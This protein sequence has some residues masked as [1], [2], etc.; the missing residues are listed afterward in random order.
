MGIHVSLKNAEG[1]EHPDWDWVRHAGDREIPGILDGME[2]V[3]LN[4][5]GRYDEW[6]RRPTDVAAFRKRLEEANGEMNADRWDH[7][8][9]LLTDNPRFGLSWTY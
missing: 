2:T 5:S 3:D 7:L 1:E 9:R 4:D 6:C 8:C